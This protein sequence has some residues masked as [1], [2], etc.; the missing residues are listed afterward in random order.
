MALI[1]LW[2][3]SRVFNCLFL[4]LNWFFSLSSH[5]DQFWIFLFNFPT[6]FLGLISFI[7]I[8]RYL[9]MYMPSLSLGCRKCK[10]LLRRRATLAAVKAKVVTTL[11]KTCL[12][13]LSLCHG[14]LLCSLL[15]LDFSLFL[16]IFLFSRTLMFN[17]DI[18]ET[19]LWTA[20]CYSPGNWLGFFV[21]S[22]KQIWNN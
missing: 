20:A 14:W 21:L 7:W 9:L 10:C 13:C 19:G 17:T 8:C 2:R 3:K 4:S 22:E 5:L 11:G 1:S 6:I 16:R 12:V 18:P 15:L